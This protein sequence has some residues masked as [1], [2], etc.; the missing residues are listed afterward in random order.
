MPLK[1]AQV[2]ASDS[3][4][5]HLLLDHILS[6][7]DQGHEVTAVCAPGKWTQELRQLGIDLE[8]VDMAR[9]LSPFA[10]L[11]SV[12]E[13]CR[14]FRRRRF[15]VVHTHT[16][17]AGLLGPLAAQLVGVTTVLHTVHGLLFHDRTPHGKRQAFWLAEK[18]TATFTDHLLSQSRED[19]HVAIQSRLCAADRITYLGNGI[20]LRRFSRRAV[21]GAREALR[22]RFGFGRTDFVV[23]S[24]GR[25]VYEKGYAELF[26]A[27]ERISG[28]HPDIR[29]LIVG[30][31]EPDQ[32]DAVSPE[33]ITALS[34]SGVM[35]FA[36]WR[37][38]MAECYA[39]M[40]AFLLPSHRE[41]IPRA[42]ME[43]SAMELPVV[44]TN[45]RGCREVVRQ[46]ETGLLIP[47]RDISAIVAAV[48][49]LRADG[50]LAAWMG[51]RGRQHIM[52]NFDQQQVLARLCAFYSTLD[53][54]QAKRRVAA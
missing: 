21:E 39:A 2:A 6:L 43:A 4:I 7:D 32:N 26:E 28:S 48:E 11:K 27:A 1:I 12:R 15:D 49:K 53:S 51:R 40:D 25:L 47:M 46:G 30:P 14:L 41:G 5:R 10:D 52:E 42:L 16:P 29:F 38:D 3:A 24:V 18:F 50:A 13:L 35:V 45:V 36:G 31:Q 19:M 44:A 37:N 17:K 34:R 20:D 23:G 54:E 9:E 22:Q 33:R 8:T